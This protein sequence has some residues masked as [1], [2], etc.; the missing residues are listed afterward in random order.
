[1]SWWRRWFE[2][3]AME[4]PVAEPKPDRWTARMAALAIDDLPALL[5]D[6]RHEPPVV[7]EDV[8]RRARLRLGAH[9]S[10]LLAL[11]R[12][13]PT[14]AQS[15]WAGLAE[16][17]EHAAEACD[18]LADLATESA[19]RQAYLER[20]AAAAPGD[21][22]RL[23]RCLGKSHRAAAPPLPQGAWAPLAERLPVRFLARAPIAR[24]PSGGVIRVVADAAWAAKGLRADLCDHPA[25]PAL[26]ADLQR[27]QGL[28]LPGLST[29]VHL[30]AAQGCWV[31]TLGVASLVDRPGVDLT[32]VAQAVDALHAA[33]L[34]HGNICPQNVIV[35]ADG[36]ARLTDLGVARLRGVVPSVEADRAALERLSQSMREAR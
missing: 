5:I 35:D 31:R 1:M 34:T 28:D 21:I 22:A 24:G 32:G 10:L 23:R 18:A 25:L 16:H 3:D 7:R 12:T 8:L 4:P 20:A 26:F 15:L 17:P 30:D 11:A 36:A 14:D 9:P 27:A 2:S 29:I 13:T 19:A 6:L 33:G